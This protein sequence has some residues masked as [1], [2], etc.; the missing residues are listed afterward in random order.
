MKWERAT[1][2]IIGIFHWGRIPLA[3]ALGGLDAWA[4]RGSFMAGDTVSYM[5]M[6]HRIAAGEWSR[7][8]NG[9]WSPL[10]PILLSVFVRPFLADTSAQFAAVRLANFLIFAATTGLF[11]IFLR[12]LTKRVWVASSGGT[13]GWQRLPRKHFVV[14]AH[15]IYLGACLGLNMVARI[16]PDN[17]VLSFLLLTATIA[18]WLE[19]TPPSVWRFGLFGLV[20]GIGYWVKAIL[21]P[22][23]ILILAATF[24]APGL[25]NR[26]FLLVASIA[27]FLLVS[28]PLAVAI[29]RHCG[30]VT[31]GETGRLNYAW[32]VKGVPH[33]LHWQGDRNRPQDGMP[34]HPSRKLNS[35]PDVFE[36]ATPIA[37]TYPP[38]AEPSYWYDG[39]KARFSL[40]Q[41]T[42][43]L[44]LNA[45]RLGLIVLRTL[46]GPV[47]FILIAHRFWN[48]RQWATL[49]QESLP[50]VHLWLGAAGFL[51][52]YLCVFLLDRHVAGPLLL[53][54]LLMLVTL[55][56]QVRGASS[57]CSCSSLQVPLAGRPDWPTRRTARPSNMETF[58]MSDGKWRKNFR[59]FTCRPKQRSLPLAASRLTIGLI[60][61]G[62]AWWLK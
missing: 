52:L 44:A 38:W 42:K 30:H 22:A 62:C 56:T 2:Q 4:G 11:E 8:I 37:A 49:Y 29:S 41:Q 40:A 17:L 7:A 25:R 35:K 54:E 3:L 48:R 5:E 23:G 39:V 61:P 28:V 6:A 13:S 9:Y 27:T 34:R 36:F 51:S 60:P 46:V 32:Y 33:D 19:S 12:Q 43:A 18:L 58:T 20:M 55:R 24:F 57:Q 14:G 45:A 15:A 26:K 1:E 47:L 31:F 16:S 21:L 59:G 53:V 10:Y 50:V